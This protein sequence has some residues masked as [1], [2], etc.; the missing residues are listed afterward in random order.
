MR[1]TLGIQKCDGPTDGP[2]DIPTYT[3]RCRVACPRL[4]MSKKCN[5]FVAENERKSF[6][7]ISFL[8]PYKSF[9]AGQGR[10]HDYQS[11]VWVGRGSD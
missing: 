1:K 3:V 6:Y 4:K 2:T 9:K 5:L 7:S 11:Q 8:L 10:I